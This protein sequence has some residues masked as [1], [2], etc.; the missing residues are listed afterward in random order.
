MA[1]R[2][3]A[4]FSQ[5][6]GIAALVTLMAVGAFLGAGAIKAKTY[7]DPRDP[8]TPNAGAVEGHA[9]TVEKGQGSEGEHGLSPKET[10][11]SAAKH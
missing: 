7:G 3:E 2:K 10:G 1:D 4:N 9:A 6:W 5:G 8:L 11:D